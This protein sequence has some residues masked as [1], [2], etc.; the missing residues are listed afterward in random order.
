V[1]N[2]YVR[3]LS[4]R[5]RR[6]EFPEHW[7]ERRKRAYRWYSEDVAKA[8]FLAERQAVNAKCQGGASDIVAGAMLAVAAEFPEVVRVLV[9]V[10]DEMVWERMRGWRSSM[11]PKLRELCETG[12]GYDLNVPLVFEAQE[13]ASWADKGASVSGASSM[14]T[15]RNKRDRD[16]RQAEGLQSRKAS[17]FGD[18]GD[19]AARISAVRAKA[20]AEL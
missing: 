17:Q 3:L 18:S 11:L 5:M 19:R 14:L 4:G 15:A 9:Q 12:H 1:R 2:G 13:V 7:A 8:G 20:K 16:K 10:H 6:L